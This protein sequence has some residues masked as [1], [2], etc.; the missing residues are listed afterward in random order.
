LHD[1]RHRYGILLPKGVQG[2]NHVR[3][4]VTGVDAE[5][6]MTPEAMLGYA[7]NYRRAT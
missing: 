1:P 3:F 6:V 4:R 7:E 5:V 2:A